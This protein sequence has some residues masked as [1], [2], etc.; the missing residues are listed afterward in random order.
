MKTFIISTVVFLMRITRRMR[1][2]CMVCKRKSGSFKYC[3]FECGCY[4]GAIVRNKY[5]K[6]SYTRGWTE[7]RWGIINNKR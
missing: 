6:P 2:R 1:R 3:S 5:G 4:D 7:T